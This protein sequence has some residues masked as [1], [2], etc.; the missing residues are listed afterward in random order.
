MNKK[1]MIYQA[2]N[3][4]IELSVDSNYDTVWA[5][6]KQ[7]AEIFS[8]S[9][10][11]ITI[12]LKNIFAS[13]ELDQEATCKESLQVQKEGKREVKRTVK[14]Y[15]LDVLISIGY[16]IDSILGTNFRKWATKTL[17]EHITK[18]FTL[19]ENLLK[20]KEEL[21]LQ[22]LEDIKK[23]S[24]DNPYISN[25]QIIDL[26][27]NFSSTWFNLESYDKQ[28]LPKRGEDNS[29]ISLD[30]ASLSKKLYE[31]V[32]VFKQE[33]IS[34]KEASQLFAQEKVKGSLGGT[35]GNVFQSAFGQDAYE[36]IE[37][38]AAHL[39][40]FIVKNHPFD[41]GNKRTGAF[42]F[43]WFLDKAK[44]D[45]SDLI[46]PQ[47]LTALTLLIAESNPKDKDKMVGLI[48]LL[49]KR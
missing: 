29:S 37:E 30:R 34:K 14:E 32:D 6:Q 15:N 45:F 12:H 43:I 26:I 10:Q 38:K 21:Y 40:Y 9:P 28:D 35:L 23:L 47:T 1:P 22:V 39:L 8:V 31:E 48:L 42:S 16:R 4:A 25:T 7:I 44:F 36:T 13:G 5:S 20:Q 41:D 11:N 27:K 33:L 17:K 49:L 2:E 18:G 46:N 3:G 19:N 24:S